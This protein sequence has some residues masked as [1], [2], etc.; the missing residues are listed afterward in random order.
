MP[1][2]DQILCLCCDIVQVL[3]ALDVVVQV[4]VSALNTDKLGRIAACLVKSSQALIFRCSSTPV[5]VVPAALGQKAACWM[6]L[7]SVSQKLANRI[8]IDRRK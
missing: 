2:C 7:L 5:L 6:L 4:E 3:K 8:D 1:S